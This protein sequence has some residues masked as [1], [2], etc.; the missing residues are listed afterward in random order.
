MLLRIM[1][2]KKIILLI[3]GIFVAIAICLSTSLFGMRI[4]YNVPLKPSGAVLKSYPDLVFIVDRY[5]DGNAMI[6]EF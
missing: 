4:A 5:V 6:A 2:T 1:F 3:V